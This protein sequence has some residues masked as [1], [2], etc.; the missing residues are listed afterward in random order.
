[1]EGVFLPWKNCHFKFDFLNI[2]P[3]P[4][5]SIFLLFI[6]QI[7]LLNNQHDQ[8]HADASNFATTLSKSEA[9]TQLLSSL[10]SLLEGQR[11]WVAN[12]ANT[13]SLLWHLYH[14]LPTPSSAVNW[15][16]FYVLDPTDPS[17][18]LILGPF[19]GKVACQTIR[20][21]K[22][23]CGV[24][25]EGAGR[26][27]LVK[28]VE[29][30]PG[31]IACDGDSKSE[32]VVAIRAGGKVWTCRCRS[33]LL[34]L[35]SSAYRRSTGRRRDRYRLCGTRGFRRGRPEGSRSHS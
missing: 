35:P 20:I 26:T 4:F 3:V 5:T 7:S 2:L 33:M 24:A 15:S 30:F 23:V 18:Q 25:A 11:N 31:H 19:M 1:M 29:A 28:D 22:G 21:G 8:P 34:L 10:E 14:S 16:G 32:I 9:Y 12:T 13:A 17:N 6:H 27:V